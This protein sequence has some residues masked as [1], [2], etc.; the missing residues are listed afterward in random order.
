MKD[1]K[2]QCLEQLGHLLNDI[3]TSAQTIV[4]LTS[5]LEPKNEP[6]L[7]EALPH[8]IYV[9]SQRMGWAADMAAERLP[10]LSWPIVG[11]AEQWMMPPAY[12]A[13]KNKAAD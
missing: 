6:E 10:A 13:A 5:F 1:R 12:H 4:T 7:L 8:A 2:P 9:L 11:D 3:A